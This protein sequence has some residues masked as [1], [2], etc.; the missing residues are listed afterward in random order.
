MKSRTRSSEQNTRPRFALSNMGIKQKFLVGVAAPLVFTAGIGIT[1]LLSLAQLEQAQKWVDHTQKVLATASSIVASAVDMETGMRGYLL[2][3][4][5]GFLEPYNS[6]TT[7]TFSTLAELQQTVSDNPPQV[8]RL[9]EADRILREWQT[10]VVEPR[11]EL[12]QTIGDS[13]TMNDMA[14]AVAEGRGKEYFD[15]FRRLI[16]EFADNET[17]HLKTRSQGFS[18]VL[19]RGAADTT[20]VRNALDWVSHTYEVIAVSKDILAAAVDMETGMRGFLLAGDDAF[21]AP[22]TQG[23]ATFERLTSS[24]SETVRDNPSQVAHLAKA[25]EVIAEWQENVVTPILELRRVI[26]DAKTMDDMADLIAKAEG[27]V[28]F[29]AFRKL[30]SE[31]ASEEQALMQARVAANEKAQ[32]VSK[33]TIIAAVI[34]TLVLGFGIAWRMGSRLGHAVQSLTGGMQ[35]LADGDNEADILGQERGDELGEMARATDVFKQ[36]A[37]RVATLQA[38]TEANRAAEEDRKNQEIRTE[39]ERAERDKRDAEVARASAENERKLER[40]IAEEISGVVSACAN[41]DFSQRLSL[42]GKEGIFAELCHGVNEIGDSTDKSLSEVSRAILALSKGDLSYRVCNSLEGIFGEIAA[43]VNDSMESLGKIIGGIRDSSVVADQS[44]EELSQNANDLSTRTEQNAATLEE[45]NAAL[46][47]LEHSVKKAAGSAD[48][49]KSRTDEVVRVT[50]DGLEIVEQTITAMRSIKQSSK[51]IGQVVELIESISFQTN[52][53]ALNAGVEAA[54]AGESGRGFAVVA[55]EVRELAARSSEAAK[56]ISDMISESGIEVS[57]GVDLADKS[58]TLLKTI[59][60]AVTKVSSEIDLV[61]NATQEQKT[62]IL[63]ITTASTDLDKSTQ[64]NA[65]MFEESNSAIAVMR[66]EFGSL[67][68]AVDEFRLGDQTQPSG[69]PSSSSTVRGAVALRGGMNS[70]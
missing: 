22:L 54:R 39:K 51:K 63:E 49:A 47:E 21:L 65:A 59:A 55:T 48:D 58:G 8:E 10:V 69:V 27:K 66:S 2:A 70:I 36:N 11:I 3:G 62:R 12:R 9:Q 18:T 40:M 25:S 43:D 28:Y 6:G 67:L 30:M 13:P 37:I 26:G 15:E 44:A 68:G 50:Q 33:T 24:L 64:R 14:A 45:T 57:N 53:L 19:S 41:G 52:L 5:V 20:A 7:L 46:I 61:A 32:D 16:A 17:V 42:Q 29:D 56:D 38:E 4:D 1:A 60:D 23:V 34:A 35:R 31:F